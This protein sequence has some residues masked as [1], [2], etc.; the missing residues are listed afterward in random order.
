[1]HPVRLLFAILFF[2][3]WQKPGK[4]PLSSDKIIK[5]IDP[6]KLS[7]IMNRR[8][9]LDVDIEECNVDRAPVSDYP[10][11][12]SGQT[13]FSDLLQWDLKVPGEHWLDGE[14]F[15][16]EIQMLHAHLS[17]PRVSSIGIPIRAT[18]NGFNAAFQEILDQF[19]LTY[20]ADKARCEAKK[21]SRRRAA[22]MADVDLAKDDKH[23]TPFGDP[24][25]ARKLQLSSKEFNPY[26]IAFL[27]T[28][29]FFRYDGTTT[30][31]PCV[32]LTWWVMSSPMRISFEQLDQAKHL[33]FTHVNGDCEKT[34]VHNA[35]QSVARP[36]QKRAD[37]QFVMECKEGDFKA[38]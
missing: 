12:S 18:E 34:S 5:R 28:I 16:A 32:F 17:S 7:I 30:D 6:N 3:H 24:D 26:S 29:F 15:D 20:D 4:L 8:A 31:P 35:D 33:L 11:Y 37:D 23:H 2:I 9:C 36:L 22:G 25:S 14:S 38:D 13:H 19:Q 27:T 1:M 21:S 10:R